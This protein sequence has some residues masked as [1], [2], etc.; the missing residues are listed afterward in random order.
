MRNADRLRSQDGVSIAEVLISALLIFIIILV[1]TFIAGSVKETCVN[2]ANH[3]EANKLAMYTL[4]KL[5]SLR[6][7]GLPTDSPHLSEGT[8]DNASDPGFLPVGD[9]NE[10][11]ISYIVTNGIWDPANNIG[12]HKEIV[13]T[14]IWKYKDRDTGVSFAVAK[15]QE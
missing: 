10:C 6:Y 8:H 2:G 9:L 3:L 11:A 5:L 15:G 4:E 14:V 1:V 13:V 7:Q 12:Q